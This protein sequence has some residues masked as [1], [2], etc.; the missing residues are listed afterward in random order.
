[1]SRRVATRLHADEQ[2]AR[3]RLELYQALGHEETR[4]ERLVIGV[5]EVAHRYSIYLAFGF[6]RRH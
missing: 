5:V 4:R 2:R 1:M 3:L 6:E